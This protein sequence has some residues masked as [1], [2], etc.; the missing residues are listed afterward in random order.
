MSPIHLPK[1]SILLLT[2]ILLFA[3]CE[4]PLSASPTKNTESEQTRSVLAPLPNFTTLVK[5]Q[6][7]A[8]VNISSTKKIKG[9]MIL[10]GIPG[11]TPED[12]FYEFFRRFGFGNGIPHEFQSQSLGSGF[13]VDQAGYILTNSHVVEDADEVIVGLTD[14]RE[15]KAKLVGIDK[16][17]D[18]ALLKIS[19]KDLPVVSIGDPSR[20]EVGEWV[21]AIGAPFGFTNSVTQGIVSATGRDLP[22]QNIVPF[23]QTDVAINPGSSGGPLFNMNGEVVGINS[24]IFSRSGGS[25]GISFAIPIDVAMKVK[26]QLQKHG[27]VRRGKLGVAIQNVSPELA[28]SFDLKKASGALVSAVEKGGPADRAG[29]QPGDVLLQ[30]DGKEISGSADISRFISEAAPGSKVR[31]K[32]WRDG[33]AKEV[34]ATL[35]EADSRPRQAENE[36]APEILTP[37]RFGL[38]LRE[39]PPEQRQALRTEGAI[40]VED[41]EGI[42]ALSGI[43]PGD[44]ILAV[45]HQ[46]VASIA[47]L[48]SA[49]AKAGKRVALLVQR[50]ANTKLF[51]SLRLSE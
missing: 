18:V 28:E 16:R 21:V 35:G 25:M 49:L 34:T 22:G 41:V 19:A 50:D 11:L 27:T 38:S 39:L 36:L 44:V 6:G 32:F 29:L 7:P 1:T 51:I 10:P 47:Q 42:A 23:I 8:V 48:R 20:L 26:E 24:Q 31:L 30:F 9:R 46:R 13:I 37:D 5:T 17:S 43:Q 4:Q 40:A 12:P 15:F 45:N 2:S 14:K 3:G 33:A